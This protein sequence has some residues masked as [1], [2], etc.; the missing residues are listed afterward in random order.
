VRRVGNAAL[1]LTA[2]EAARLFLAADRLPGR[3]LIAVSGGPDSVALLGL[4]AEA[5]RGANLP[6]AHVAT[7]D[8]GLRAASAEEAMTVAAMAQALDLPHST[9][10]W[11]GRKPATGI[12]EAAR[13]ARYRLLARH[14]HAVGAEAVLV[15]HTLDDQ[16][17][18]VLMRLMRG[19]GLKGLGGMDG[20]T[21]SHGIGLFRPFLSVP[22]SRLIATCQDRGWDYVTDPANTNP[23]FLRARLRLLAPVL[24]KD[25][26]TPERLCTLATRMRRA[27]EAL[28]AA[29]LAAMEA[30]RIWQRGATLY[31][32]EKLADQP[33]EIIVRAFLHFIAIGRDADGGGYL[34]L[35]R[36][37]T[38]AD[39]FKTAVQRGLTFRRN[40]GG[41]LFTLREGVLSLRTEPERGA[42]RLRSSCD[43]VHP[44]LGNSP[45]D[46]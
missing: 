27:D 36:V 21:L 19:S 46:P 41:V 26:L 15:A 3:V 7:V 31:D 17:E 40:A 39:A 14:A 33:E 8:H 10:L 32:A 43:N 1:P 2:S 24:A 22:K 9:L 20:R 16:A 45:G 42:K 12:Q 37:E 6:D 23:G 44:T 35:E 11:T 29:A 38:L 30:C 28:D 18:T 13:E 34:R 5:R 25:G 4:Y